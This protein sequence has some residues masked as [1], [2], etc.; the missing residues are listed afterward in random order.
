[1]W[2]EGRNGTETEGLR[3]EN[4]GVSQKIMQTQE[5]ELMGIIDYDM[6]M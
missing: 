1:M 6:G 4:K 2:E 5:E 3:Y